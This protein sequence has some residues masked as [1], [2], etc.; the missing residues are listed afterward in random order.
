MTLR[1]ERGAS[2]GEEEQADRRTSPWEGSRGTTENYP[3]IKWKAKQSQNR[4]KK[5]NELECK[6]G[7]YRQHSALQLGPNIM[8]HSLLTKAAANGYNCF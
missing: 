3:E 4:Q 8:T 5:R 7:E 2:C 1:A 6:H